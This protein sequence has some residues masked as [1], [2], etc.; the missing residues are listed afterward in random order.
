M[1]A[2]LFAVNNGYIDDVE[3]SKVPAFEKAMLDFLKTKHAAVVD[4]IESVKEVSKDDETA[5]HEAL[6]QFKQTGAY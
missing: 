5:L 4:R 1:S 2:V 3:V 6:K